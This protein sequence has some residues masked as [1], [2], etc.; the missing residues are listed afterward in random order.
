MLVFVKVLGINL[1]YPDERSEEERRVA[2]YANMR[3]LRTKRDSKSPRKLQSW[4]ME[5]VPSYRQGEARPIGQVAANSTL[6]WG[7]GNSKA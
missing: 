3:S 2:N 7:D 5:G 4:E 6:I 1:N